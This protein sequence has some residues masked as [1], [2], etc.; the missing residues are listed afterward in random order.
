MSETCKVWASGGF[1]MT[2]ERRTR[3]I[4]EDASLCEFAELTVNVRSK[5][6]YGA[7]LDLMGFA[8]SPP[9]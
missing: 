4:G 9:R 6:D 3:T 7:F 1:V 5:M 2:N 8:L